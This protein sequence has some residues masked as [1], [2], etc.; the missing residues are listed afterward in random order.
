MDENPASGKE[1]KWP[2]R[3]GFLFLF[4]FA[5]LWSLGPFFFSTLLALSFY[6]F[7]LHF[8][9]SSDFL[10]SFRQIFSTPGKKSPPTNPF[11][12]FRPRPAASSGTA[13]SIPTEKVIRGFVLGFMI[14]FFTFFLVGI[15]FGDDESEP[16]ENIQATETIEEDDGTASWIDKG[17]AAFQNDLKDSAL[18]YYDQALAID[19]ENRYALYGKGLAY[20]LRQ[21]YQRGNGFARRCLASHPDHDLAWWLLGYSYD[22]TNQTDSALYC[23]EQAYQHDFSDT[24]FL[25]LLAEV[26]VK[27]NRRADALAM[28]QK[29]IETDT[30][31]ADLYR[32]MAELDPAHSEEYLRK[33]RALGN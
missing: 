16:I 31:Q 33:A 24:G 29:V 22:L 5:L 18:F 6:F 28:Y 1:N 12:S 9:R 3:L 30:T 23:L 10:H 19:P 8:Y 4:L 13:T 20:V 17:N 32:K 15:F 2:K 26:Y 7:F 11:Q 14:M 21:E 25:Q 27:K